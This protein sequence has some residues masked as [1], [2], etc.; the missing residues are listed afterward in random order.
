MHDDQCPRSL[1]MWQFKEETGN[2]YPC[3]AVISPENVWAEGGNSA[4][5]RS[6][7]LERGKARRQPRQSALSG[8][9]LR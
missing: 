7:H 1:G 3:I 6:R 9:R 4:L 2:P 5:K 8:T